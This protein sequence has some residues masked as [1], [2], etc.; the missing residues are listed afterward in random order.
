MFT[1]IIK[2]DGSLLDPLQHDTYGG[3]WNKWAKDVQQTANDGQM[4]AVVSFDAIGKPLSTDQDAINLLT[5]INARKI[6]NYPYVTT[7][8]LTKRI[9]YALL[10]IKGKNESIE[11]LNYDSRGNAFIDTTYEKLLN[12]S[13]YT[14][15]VNGTLKP[16]KF[17]G[18]GACVS[19]M[20]M[21]WYGMVSNIPSGWVLCDG[22]NGTPNLTERFIVAAGGQYQPHNFGNADKHQHNINISTW[23]GN[24]GSHGH[25]IDLNAQ[26]S[27]KS[28]KCFKNGSDHDGMNTFGS[29]T[30]GTQG[31]GD[32]SHSI[33]INTQSS[34]Y[35]GENRPK[36]YALCFIMKI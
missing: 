30:I 34:E 36:W 9:P 29:S 22:K 14:L 8:P 3:E 20:I 4:V 1:Q 27:W 10:F 13:N 17:V 26:N 18:E 28:V 12:L 24:G 19:G 2:P 16:T 33:N 21:M 23:T 15:T 5:S 25:T 6:L 31:V 32:H 35:G 7:D 11:V